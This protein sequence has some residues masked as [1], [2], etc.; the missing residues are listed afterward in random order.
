MPTIRTFIALE[1]PSDVRNRAA[2]LINKLSAADANV[3]YV[4]TENM[5]LTL[6]FLGDVPENDIPAVCRAAAEAAKTVEPFQIELRGAGAFPDVSRPRT[7]WIGAG[8][9][10][11]EMVALQAAIDS[12]LANL[13]F[14]REGRKF[15][16][17]LTLGRVKRSGP[18]LAELSELLQKNHKFN[19]RKA[20]I[21][22]AIVFSSELTKSGPIYTVL[23]RAPL[24]A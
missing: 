20:Q 16:P 12:S 22:E 19:A 5:H 8:E 2:D 21:D 4:D 3:R 18:G 1:M 13:R 24:G 10:E 15:H 14:P 11:E 23:G 17:H 9:G 6:K 7:L